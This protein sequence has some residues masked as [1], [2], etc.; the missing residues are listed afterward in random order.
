M[1]YE[2]TNAALTC[3]HVEVVLIYKLVCRENRQIFAIPPIS[4]GMSV[5]G[6]VVP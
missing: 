2:V 1:S 6:S 5:I 4:V 3:E